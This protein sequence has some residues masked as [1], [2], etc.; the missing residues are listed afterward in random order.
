M[1]FSLTKTIGGGVYLKIRI[2]GIFMKLEKFKSKKKKNILI[3]IL[4]IIL[5]NITLGY[6]F[7][8][9]R[10]QFKQEKSFKIVDGQVDYYGDSDVYFAF[11]QDNEKTETAPVKDSGYSLDGQSSY[12]TNEAIVLWDS[13]NWQAVVKNLNKTNTKCYLY[14][15]KLY[16][17]KELNGADPE[18]TKD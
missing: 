1:F 4:F 18:L 17:D 5:I 2:E 11:F 9:S 12:C 6:L 8:R 3:I 16:K 13:T 10:A 7:T 15:K 14:F